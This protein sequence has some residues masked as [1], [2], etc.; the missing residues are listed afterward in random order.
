VHRPIWRDLALLRQLDHVH[1]WRVT[2]LCGM[3]GI[4]MTPQACSSGRHA[5]VLQR[6]PSTSS[7]PNPDSKAGRA[8]PASGRIRIPSADSS[9][10]CR[11]IKIKANAYTGLTNF[12]KHNDQRHLG[13]SPVA[14]KQ[15]VFCSCFG[16]A[17]CSLRRLPWYLRFRCIRGWLFLSNQFSRSQRAAVRKCLR[18]F[19]QRKP[20]DDALPK[21]QSR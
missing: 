9:G 11:K 7:Q 2:A 14:I 15:R 8:R 16:T 19:Y 5:R 4:S 3:T 1:G 18:L 10:R 6:C 12:E 21:G 20:R 17:H 13:L